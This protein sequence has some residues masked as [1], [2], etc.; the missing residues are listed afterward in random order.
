[1]VFS[2]VTV[3]NIIYPIP[4]RA[5][6]QAS[7]SND[8]YSVFTAY[9]CGVWGFLLLQGYFWQKPLQNN[10]L[11]CNSVCNT[12]PR[13]PVARAVGASFGDKR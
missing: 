1:M 10:N 3:C 11:S 2:L 5:Q 12:H 9:I 6:A 13:V 7:L 8:R 4:M